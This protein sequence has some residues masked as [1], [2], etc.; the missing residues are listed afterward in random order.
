MTA[1]GGR[2]DGVSWND[3]CEIHHIVEIWSDGGLLLW[4]LEKTGQLDRFL[5]N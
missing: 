3:F 1:I 4:E 5:E 2:Q